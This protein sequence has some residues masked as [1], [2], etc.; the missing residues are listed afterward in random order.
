MYSVG[1]RATV[2]FHACRRVSFT[3]VAHVVRTRCRVPCYAL[4]ARITRYPR[5]SRV[6][7]AYHALSAREIKLFA[8]NHSCQLISYLFNHPQLK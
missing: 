5:V 1:P 6:I 7:R 2:L 3:S 8:Y 4:F